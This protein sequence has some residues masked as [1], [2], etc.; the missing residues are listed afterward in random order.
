MTYDILPF[1]S[2]SPMIFIVSKAHKDYLHILISFLKENFNARTFNHWAVIFTE[3]GRKTLT[4]YIQKILVIH[5][6]TMK[7]REISMK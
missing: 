2:E 1:K 6:V 4:L 5:K 3:C 7:W